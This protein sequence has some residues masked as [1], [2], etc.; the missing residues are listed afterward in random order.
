MDKREFINS[1]KEGALKGFR[2]YRILPSL[3]IAQAILES[4]WGSS[5]LAV[6]AKNLFGIKAFSNWRGDKISLPTKEWYNGQEQ[7][8]NA[9]FRAYGSFNESIVD[10]NKLLSNAR[11]KPVRE[12]SVYRDACRKIYEC[13]YATDPGYP[14][15]LIKIIE[16]NRLYEFDNSN[17]LS[18]V[19]TGIDTNKVLKFQQLCNKLNIKDYEGKA[20]IEDNILG[21]RTRI[22]IAK[23]PT[24]E[25]GASGPA[26]EF[27]QNVV[28]A[29]P[30]DGIFGVLTKNCVIEYQETKDIA[31][32]GIVGIQTWI[33]MITT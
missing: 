33:T 2:E 15:K 11:Y 16:E 12:C 4:G 26:V 1:I 23:M 19:A 17:A 18:E 20:L 32:D 21:P 14:E 30:I 10:H 6:T 31:V 27:V 28:N 22:C 8:V 5:Q 7:I 25:I 13:S 24:L 3:T 9:D 29:V